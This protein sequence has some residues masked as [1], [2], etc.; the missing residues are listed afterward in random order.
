M[1]KIYITENQLKSVMRL[2]E[3]I[4][5]TVDKKPGEDFDSAL[6]RADTEVRRD[7]PNAEVNYVVPQDELNDDT[8]NLNVSDQVADY[9]IHHWGDEL[10]HFM[11]MSEI[12]NMIQDAYIEVTGEILKDSYIKREILNKIQS[13]FFDQIKSESFIVTKKQIKEAKTKKKLSEAVKIISKK[14]LIE[15]IKK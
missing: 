15:N 1:R 5:Q 10:D 11:P 8:T 3:T 2:K 6:R 7:A 14:D 12:L 9:I 4:N 13:K